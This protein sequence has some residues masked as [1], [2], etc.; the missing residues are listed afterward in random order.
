M[1]KELRNGL[2]HEMGI[3]GGS[4]DD[5]GQERFALLTGNGFSIHAELLYSDF[6]D[7]CRKYSYRPHFLGH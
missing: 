6:K 3:R 4:M 2:A 7:G 5:P 1:W